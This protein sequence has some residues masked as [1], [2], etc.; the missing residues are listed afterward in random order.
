MKRW[1][2]LI[3]VIVL[4]WIAF[5]VRVHAITGQEPF[6]DEGYHVHRALKVWHFESHPAQESHGKFLLY[7]W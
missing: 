6:I 1:A 5:V 2:H 7:F 4:L 3:L